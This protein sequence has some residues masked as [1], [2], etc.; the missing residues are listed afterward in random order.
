MTIEQ[1]LT[2]CVALIEHTIHSS[3][4]QALFLLLVVVVPLFKTL[5]SFVKT[6]K[7]ITLIKQQAVREPQKKLQLLIERHSLSPALFLISSEDYYMAFS[8]GFLK[9][10]IILSS[11]LVEDFSI[12]E[13]EAVIL[14]ELHHSKMNHSILLFFGEL[15]A[16]TFF[17]FPVFCDLLELVKTEFEKSADAFAVQTQQ[18]NKYVKASL[19]KMLQFG[20]PTDLAFVP[21]FSL[22]VVEQRIDSLNAVSTRPS[23]RFRASRVLFSLIALAGCISFHSFFVNSALARTMEEHIQC[24]FTECVRNCVANEIIMSKPVMSLSP[25]SVQN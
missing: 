17:I 18:T 20:M 13:L 14:H 24:S 2:S 4:M 1:T 11:K 25:E 22:H 10:N 19:K 12:H 8:I 15:F 6:S 21:Q 7:K 9:K 5:F 3:L 23:A 16:Q